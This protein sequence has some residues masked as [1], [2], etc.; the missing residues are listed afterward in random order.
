[1]M[2]SLLPTGR[3]R[4]ARHCAAENSCVNWRT[5]TTPARRSA[6]SKTSVAADDGRRMRQRHLRARG[7]GG[8]PF[9]TTTGLG[10][11]GGA[12]RAHEAAALRMPSM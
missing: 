4:E 8:R 7:L 11:G 5:R 9:I 3:K 10:V 1:M 6:A 2:P 12:Q